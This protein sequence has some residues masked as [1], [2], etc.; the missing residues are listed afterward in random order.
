MQVGRHL[1]CRFTSAQHFRQTSVHANSFSQN[2][3]LWDN[4]HLMKPPH[5]FGSHLAQRS[6]TP[7]TL[8]AMLP[9]NG[10]LPM[11]RFAC[12]LK[13]V[14]G[15][16]NKECSALTVKTNNVDMVTKRYLS[17]RDNLVISISASPL[18][19]QLTISTFFGPLHT[20]HLLIRKYDISGHPFKKSVMTGL[21]NCSSMSTIL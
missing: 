20:V 10:L 3:A 11:L 21:Y 19:V 8:T 5:E 6:N 9:Q 18:L 4:Q 1:A 2:T 16:N 12:K 17:D 7:E 13:Q 14:A 15:L